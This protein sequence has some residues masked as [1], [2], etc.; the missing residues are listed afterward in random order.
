MKV[1]V[2]SYS[3]SQYIAQGKMTVYDTVVKAAQMGFDAIEFTTIQ[4]ADGKTREQIAAELRKL[5][6]ENKIEISAYVVGGNL[7]TRDEKERE[8]QLNI[9]KSEVN[10]AS[11]LGVKLFRHDV[12]YML[13]QGMCFYEA[14][15][16][17]APIIRE[18]SEYA[19]KSGIKTMIEN[20][21]RAFQDADR[22]E[23]TY[24]IVNHKNFALLVD[25]G[26][27]MCADEDSVLSVSR[28]ANLAAHVH[29][30]DFIKKDFYDTQSKEHYFLTRGCNYLM[31][32]AAGYGDAKAAQCIEVLK[33]AGYDGYLDIEFEGPED[34]ICELK[35]GL[36][37]IRSVL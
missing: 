36:E 37:F 3:Y 28:V 4:E 8:E 17:A 10:I 31:G 30:K 13:P 1:G 9:L 24:R 29:L 14:S 12:G 21:G 16:L 20:H 33:Q 32:T 7:I 22:M 15:E 25:I 6:A 27:F 2:S 34:C 23:K 35:K 19:E 26:N 5:A 11:I 18:V